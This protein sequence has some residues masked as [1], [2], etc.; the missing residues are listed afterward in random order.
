MAI[1]PSSAA[2][3]YASALKALTSGG[4]PGGAEAGAQATGG[5]SF[6]D[7][8]KDVVGDSIKAGKTAETQAISGAANKAELVDVV[9]AITNAELS[10]QTVVAVRDKVVAAYQDIM[11]MPI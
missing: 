11:K 8:V 2:Q 4:A 10:L 5:T 6:A 7:M 9:T 1:N 3:A